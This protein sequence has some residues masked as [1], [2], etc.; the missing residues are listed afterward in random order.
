V[1]NLP[2]IRKNNSHRFL[3]KINDVATKEDRFPN[4][5][6]G[7]WRFILRRPAN[8]RSNIEH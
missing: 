4:S 2:K 1:K 3:A 5:S 8:A 7:S 6:F